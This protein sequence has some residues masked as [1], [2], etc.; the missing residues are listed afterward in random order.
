MLRIQNEIH[1]AAAFEGK[2]VWDYSEENFQSRGGRAYVN[3]SGF[4][5][6]MELSLGLTGASFTGN[7]PNRLTHYWKCCKGNMSGNFIASFE[8]D[9]LAVAGRL[10]VWRDYLILSGWLAKPVM[11]GE[12]P[13][14]LKIIN[15]VETQFS[16]EKGLFEGESDRWIKVWAEVSAEDFLLP[17]T[18]AGKKLVCHDGRDS[19]TPLYL[20]IIDRLQSAGM[21]IEFRKPEVHAVDESSTLAAIQRVLIQTLEGDQPDHIKPED[22]GSFQIVEIKERL[23][24]YEYLARLILSTDKKYQFIGS[25]FGFNESGLRKFGIPAPAGLSGTEVSGLQLPGLVAAPL[26]LPQDVKSLHAFL[27]CR[28]CPI[29]S[30]L[31]WK[32]RNHLGRNFG[33]GPQWESTIADWFRKEKEEG[34][35]IWG[36]L[37]EEDIRSIIPV[38]PKP[39]RNDEA[40]TSALIRIFRIVKKWAGAAERLPEDSPLFDETEAVAENVIRFLESWDDESMSHVKFNRAMKKLAVQKSM[41]SAERESG[42]HSLVKNPGGLVGQADDII[43]LN[44]FDTGSGGVSPHT[45]LGTS[46]HEFLLKDLGERSYF[47]ELPAVIQKREWQNYCRGILQARKK[48]L[49]V[50]PESMALGSGRHPLMS[51]LNTRLDLLMKRP[52]TIEEE[53]EAFGLKNWPWTELDAFPEISKTPYFEMGDPLK[54]W[55]RENLLRKNLQS[56]EWELNT[57]ES[58][59]SLEKLIQKP[60]KWLLSKLNHFRDSN[61]IKFDSESLQKGNAFHRL[62]ELVLGIQEADRSE[63][64][65]RDL[66]NQAILE[67]AAFLLLPENRIHLNQFTDDAMDGLAGLMDFISCN[68]FEVLGVERSFEIQNH[69][70]IPVSSLKGKADLLLQNNDGDKIV[71][72]LKWSSKADK[73]RTLVKGN[74]SVQLS[75]YSLID[76]GI[77]SMAYL[78]FPEKVLIGGLASW[79]IP[80]LMNRQPTEPEFTTDNA[81]NTILKLKNSILF[82]AAELAEGRIETGTGFGTDDLNYRKNQTGRLITQ[83]EEKTEYQTELFTITQHFN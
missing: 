72:D 11:A 12:A 75:V 83:T 58:P 25:A 46:V 64:R 30:G 49:L 4:L 40:T 39:N 61:A 10:L 27:S 7:S 59:T 78:V 73:F 67:K 34:N 8:T 3:F 45:E 32:L 62:V 20:N 54:S 71:I 50:I 47:P 24:L 19:I 18:L 2:P 23:P 38:S 76:E 31:R 1:L 56:G 65:R 5:A 53:M 55:V 13:E 28:P 52:D 77:Q 81:T 43:W 68:G 79:K 42:S 82:R 66:L 21:Q 33:F 60:M 80:A 35:S 6:Q 44:F 14:I 74:D 22:D 17:E 16:A 41:P 48:C 63:T 57:I 9:G 51:V 36:G 29:P 69:P 26:F 70:D 37:S 15:S